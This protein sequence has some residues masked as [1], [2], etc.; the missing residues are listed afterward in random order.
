[1]PIKAQYTIR[2]VTIDHQKPEEIVN[3]VNLLVEYVDMESGEVLDE[4]KI[5][6]TIDDDILTARAVAR[7]ATLDNKLSWD[8]DDVLAEVKVKL[9]KMGR[10]DPD[11]VTTM[12]VV[13][14]VKVPTPEE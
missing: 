6:V 12:K 9:A 3:R 10:A 11:N 1:M 8:D 14:T 7:G 5:P 13:T 2:Q 4:A